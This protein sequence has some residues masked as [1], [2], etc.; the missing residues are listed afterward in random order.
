MGSAA[1]AASTIRD[2]T[3]VHGKL[4]DDQTRCAHWSGPTDV[5][6]I[7]FKC[8]N[9]YYPCFEC[10]AEA[11]PH[12]AERWGRDEFS[13][14]AVMCGVCRAELTIETYLGCDFTCPACGAAFNPGC[15]FHHDLYF[16]VEGKSGR[17]DE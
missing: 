1:R 2:V 7:R 11:E 12:T 5:I 15:A 13:Q 16:D 8:C 6:A 4:V 14:P 10:H 3:T 17:S 9:R